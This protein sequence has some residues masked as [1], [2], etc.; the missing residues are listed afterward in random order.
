MY[1]QKTFRYI[2][3]LIVQQTICFI[4]IHQVIVTDN[5]LLQNKLIKYLLQYLKV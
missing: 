3:V 1:L 5:I 2:F 4:I